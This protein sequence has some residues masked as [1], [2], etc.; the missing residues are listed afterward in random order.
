MRD[1]SSEVTANVASVSAVVE[2]NAAAAQEMQRTTQ[3]LTAAM[4]PIADLATQQSASASEVANS[5]STLSAQAEAIATSAQQVHQQAEI[6]TQSVAG[7]TIDE[8]QGASSASSSGTRAQQRAKAR[9][10]QTA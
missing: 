9:A 4:L 2:E 3:L 5:A 7:F 1:V 10:F 6:L 8:A